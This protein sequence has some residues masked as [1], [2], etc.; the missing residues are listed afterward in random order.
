MS[1][2]AEVGATGVELKEHQ[3][4]IKKITVSTKWVAPGREMPE[5]VCATV[6]D[7]TSGEEGRT[8]YLISSPKG[9]KVTI[10]TEREEGECQRESHRKYQMA[11]VDFKKKKGKY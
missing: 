11:W 7:N 5:D 2:I 6:Y 1:G 3:C 4:G 10:K 8:L 9:K